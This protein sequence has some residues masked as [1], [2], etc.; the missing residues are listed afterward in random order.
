MNRIVMWIEPKLMATFNSRILRIGPRSRDK[1]LGGWIETGRKYG[2]AINFQSYHARHWQSRAPLHF[3]W[4]EFFW[5]LSCFFFHIPPDFI[6]RLVYHI[7]SFVFNL[8]SNC[9]LLTRLLEWHF[10]VQ[11]I[12]IVLMVVCHLE[13]L[14][15]KHVRYNYNKNFVS[16]CSVGTCS[17]SR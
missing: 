17:I 11:S 10:F 1:R 3:G 14:V 6:A 4:I 12:A 9:F 5:F 8:I 2:R 15:K 16:A 13:W 7:L